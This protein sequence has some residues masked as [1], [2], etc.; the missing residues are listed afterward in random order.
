M[1]WYTR[2]PHVGW[3]VVLTLALCIL[4]AA[5]SAIYGLYAKRTVDRATAALED[6]TRGRWVRLDSG[7]VVIRKKPAR[8]AVQ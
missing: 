7:D 4:L 8:A 1:M 6:L 3:Y 5:G 2:A